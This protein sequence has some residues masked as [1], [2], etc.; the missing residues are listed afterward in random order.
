MQIYTH[1]VIF[2]RKPLLSAYKGT[3]KVSVY[4]NLYTLSTVCLDGHHLMS[5]RFF[6]FFFTIGF[7]KKKPLLTVA[8]SVENI[9]HLVI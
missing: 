6:L 4:Q 7:W 9:V 5:L 1:I 8:L 2:T 3:H